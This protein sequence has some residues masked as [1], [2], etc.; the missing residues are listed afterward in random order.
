MELCMNEAGL[1]KVY[2]KNANTSHHNDNVI[3][4]TEWKEFITKVYG[5]KVS[6]K[7]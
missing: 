5:D 2:Q 4:L 7:L 1:R 6:L 3:S